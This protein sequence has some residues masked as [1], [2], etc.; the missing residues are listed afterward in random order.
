MT[1]HLTSAGELTAAGP[2]GQDRLWAQV[3][4]GLRSLLL[5]PD[6][7][8]EEYRSGFRHYGDGTSS[9]RGRTPSI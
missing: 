8:P 4:D 6:T 7:V 2:G 9:S 3:P 1:R 5:S